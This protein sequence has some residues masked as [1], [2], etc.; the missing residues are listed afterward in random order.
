MTVHG[1]LVADRTQPAAG[2]RKREVERVTMLAWAVAVTTVLDWPVDD[3]IT[4]SD[5]GADFNPFRT[6]GYV[7][8]PAADF[9]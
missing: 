9:L 7:V 1:G 8:E 4:G 5:S 2:E 6:N 3:P